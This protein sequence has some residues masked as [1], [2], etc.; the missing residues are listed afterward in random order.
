MPLPLIGASLV[1]GLV[2]GA[3]RDEAKSNPAANLDIKVK[4]TPKDPSS[5]IRKK[6]KEMD[7]KE[8]RA[9]SIVAQTGINIILDRTGKGIGVDGPFK[10]YAPQYEAFRSR[11]GRGTTPD[12]MFTGRMLGSMTSQVQGDKAIIFFSGPEQQKK[13]AFNNKSRR[14]MAFTKKE[15][16]Q[17]T[18]VFK[19]HY[20]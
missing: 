20:L 2:A 11:E 6:K 18:N 7:A 17:L 1:R 15:R 19:K 12:L 4:M 13:A 14:F 5:I 8:R 9:L 16:Q 10:S 3:I